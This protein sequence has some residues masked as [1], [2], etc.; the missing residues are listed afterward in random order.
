MAELRTVNDKITITHECGK[1]YK[2]RVSNHLSGQ[3]CYSCKS[4]LGE[5]RVRKFLEANGIEYR[6]QFKI[7]GYSYRYDFYLPDLNLLIEYDGEQHYRPVEFF[8]GEEYFR[9]TRERDQD[10]NFLAKTLGFRLIRIPFRSFD[11]IE[12]FL[13]RAIDRLFPYRVDGVFLQIHKHS[14]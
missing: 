7:D 10:K 5:A 14:L 3:G 2:A 4:S 12:S 11:V 13:S 8:G 9:K 1:V 6:D